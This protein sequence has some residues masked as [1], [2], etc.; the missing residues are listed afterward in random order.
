[1]LFNTN[2]LPPSYASSRKENLSFLSSY[3]LVI[4]NWPRRQTNK[5]KGHGAHK[6]NWIFYKV[7]CDRNVNWNYRF[8]MD[9]KM[10]PGDDLKQLFQS[11]IATWIYNLKEIEYPL[12]I[13]NA[14]IWQKGMLWYLCWYHMHTLRQSK[15]KL[16][17]TGSC[18]IQTLK[19]SRFSHKHNNTI[20]SPQIRKSRSSKVQFDN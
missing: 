8:V 9:S 12:G 11:T 10:S 1:M 17:V 5:R 13:P 4:F 18:T 2:H 14:I 20:D 16:N 3:S 19:Q 6:E 7:H 15:G